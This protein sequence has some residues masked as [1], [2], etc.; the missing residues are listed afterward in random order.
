MSDVAPESGTIIDYLDRDHR[1]LKGL[2]DRFQVSGIDEWGEVFRQLVDYLVRHEVAEE[3]VVFPALRRALPSSGEVLDD[4]TV[5]QQRSFERLIAMEQISPK[6]PEFRDL[7]GHLRDDLLMHIAHEEQV[8]IPL[9][10]NTRLH[11]DPEIVRSY[12]VARTVAPGRPEG[13][14]DPEALEEA[15]S[16]LTALFEKVRRAVLSHPSSARR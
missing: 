10:R 16:G 11:D 12:E 8:L 6:D 7:V 9:L 5:E 15:S 1:V 13:A 4:C 14:L 3:E 2:V